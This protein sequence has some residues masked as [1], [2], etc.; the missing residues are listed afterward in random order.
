MS[1]VRN[2]KGKVAGSLAASSSSS[3]SSSNTGTAKKLT[4]AGGS[5]AFLVKLS[6]NRNWGLD[7][8]W[9][10]LSYA[11]TQYHDVLYM[12]MSASYGAVTLQVVS[13]DAYYNLLCNHPI[14]N[15]NYTISDDRF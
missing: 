2:V 6:G 14:P 8:Q 7:R 9:G 5:R 13:L 1:A 12:I 3:S 11:K 15:A 10:P 4:F